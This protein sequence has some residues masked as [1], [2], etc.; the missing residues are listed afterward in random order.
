MWNKFIV[1]LNTIYYLKFVQIL[2]QVLH[3]L[4]H[5]IGYKR[6]Y[7]NAYKKTIQLKW[8]DGISN[9]KSFNGN[10]KF[11]FIN[12]EYYFEEDIEWNCSHINKLWNYNLNYF[13]YLNQRDIT[14]EQGLSLM[15]DFSV[16]YNEI[17]YGKD[18]YPTS[19]RIINW[20]KF[21]AK[22]RII[23]EILYKIIREDAQRL[24]KNLEYHLLGNHLLEN[25]YALWFAAHFFDDAYYFKLSKRIITKQLDEQVLKDG[26]HFELSPMYHQLMLYRVLDCTRLAQLNPCDSNFQ[27]LCNLK[28][29]AAEMSA[30]LEGVSYNS[31]AI[32]LVNDSADG[33]NPDTNT[34]LGYS[35][36]LGIEW[37]QSQLL[38]SGYR[39]V[40]REQY[41]LF[42]DVGEIGASYQPGHAHADT[43]NF[44]LYINNR[45]C[46]VD[47]GISTYDLG[48]LRSNERST[49]SH[50]TVTIN[51]RNSS[52][53]WG[54]FRVGKRA[55]I[56]NLVEFPQS[57]EAM[58]DGY[59]NYR[60]NHQR[61]WEWSENEIVVTDRIIGNNSRKAKAYFH[62]HPEISIQKHNDGFIIND[63]IELIMRNASLIKI[64]DYEYARE[65][66]IRYAAKC[67]EVGFD[68]HL[69]T[70]I[71][72][73]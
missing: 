48:D 28:D 62:L 1:L 55:R 4:R 14:K 53:V 37:N 45:P 24:S 60:L 38:D 56:I 54:G 59:K 36:S 40:R 31:G 3:R 25:G 72:I 34:I 73:G 2:Y 15:L 66:N 49:R 61:K 7:S 65:F 20:V 8:N 21:I 22:H 32:P 5:I 30:W 16:N 43:F 33:V 13:D 52:E 29:K 58:H 68:N 11:I 41:E 26:G 17:N 67:I 10:N 18:S 12:I 47:T 51:D 6:K 39:M 23:D 44:E 69:I 63:N 42:I 70:K 27:T 46:F 57:I 71:T 50:N 9:I 64:T 19:L 35:K